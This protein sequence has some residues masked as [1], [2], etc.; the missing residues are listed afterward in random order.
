MTIYD[1]DIQ[2]SIEKIGSTLKEMIKAPE[3][4]NFVKTGSGRER[5]PH[6]EDWYFVRAASI[7]VTV[8][9]KGPIGVSKLRTKYGNKKNRG[10]APERFTRASGKIIR[11]IFQQLEKLDLV[12]YK[13]EG[14]HKGRIITAKGKSLVDKNAVIKK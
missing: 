4:V 12:S 6:R 7:L 13:K 11:S 3:W 1:G 2:Q 14:V 5:P 10:H 8:Y 9:K